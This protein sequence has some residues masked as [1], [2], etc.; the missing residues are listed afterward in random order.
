MAE[1][2]AFDDFQGP[3]EQRAVERL[4]EDLPKGWTLICNKQIVQNERSREIDVI[5][6]APHTV[7][8]IEE[9]GW[10]GVIRGTENGW[11]VHGELRSSPL[12]QCEMSSKM[13]AGILRNTV[14]SRLNDYRTNLVIGIV[15]MSNSTV[16]PAIQDSRAKNRVVLL[17]DAARKMMEL[18]NASSNA[19]FGDLQKKI[20]EQLTRLPQRKHTPELIGEFRITEQLDEQFGCEV[21]RGVHSDGSERILKVFYGAELEDAPSNDTSVRRQY[22]AQRKLA[23]DDLCPA[24]DPYFRW[25]DGRALV[26]PFAKP[27]GRTLGQLAVDGPSPEQI[28]PVLLEAFRTLTKVSEQGVVHRSLRPDR[29][30]WDPDKKKIRL[31]DF[32]IARL[33]GQETVVDRA[34]EF[35][36]D[37]PY[38]ALEARI[39]LSDATPK[40]DVY[41]LAAVLLNWITGEEP[42]TDDCWS[43]PRL[44]GMRKDIED[45]LCEQIESVL[46]PALRFEPG[47]RPS[48]GEV[49]S[50]AVYAIDA[51]NRVTSVE[52][53]KVAQ[54]KQ[55]GDP[56]Y[57]ILES[58]GKG[59]TAETFLAIDTVRGELVVL[60]RLMRPDVHGYLA[61]AE[62]RALK[63]LHHDCLPKLIDVYGPDDKF[64]LK[65]EYVEGQSLKDAWRQIR[66]ESIESKL[67]LV[68]RVSGDVLDALQYLHERNLLHRDVTPGNIL[69]PE[70]EDNR[71]LLIDLGLAVEQQEALSRV[72]TPLYLA[73]EVEQAKPVWSARCDIYGLGVLLFELL[74]EKLPYEMDG[75]SR[76][77]TRLIEID[78]QDENDLL[79]SVLTLLRDKACT[80]TPGSRF[81]SAGEMRSAILRS[82]RDHEQR[83]DEPVTTPE[84]EPDN[85]SV[86]AGTKEVPKTALTELINPFVSELRQAFRNSQLGNTNNRGMDSEFSR[87]TYV[88]TE[89]D[90]QV[91]EILSGKWK[92][93]ALSGNPGDGK[94]AFLEEV[95]REL[96]EKGAEERYSNAA[97]WSLKLNGR[98]FVSVYDA[99]ESHDGQS[100]DELL[101]SAIGPL[102]GR[103]NPDAGYTAL[104]AIN[105][106]R[107]QDL[108]STQRLS[109]RWLCD[110]LRDHMQGKA[111]ADKEVLLVDLKH[112]SPIAGSKQD[113]QS[114]FLGLLDA[115]VEP[116]NWMACSQCTAF[117]DCSIRA[118]AVALRNPT[119]RLQIV[120]LLAGVYFLAERRPTIRDLRSA[121]S[122]ALT[123]D[124]DCRQIHDEV[125]QGAGV[126]RRYYNLLFDSAAG[127]DL[128][129]NSFRELDPASVVNPKLDRKLAVGKVNHLFDVSGIEHPEP[130]NH[131][132]EQLPD[133]KR[134][135]FFEVD[136]HATDLQALL[137]PRKIAEFL[138]LVSGNVQLS[139]VLPIVLAGLQRLDRIPPHAS[140]RELALRLD[141]TEDSLIVVRRWQPE[142]FVLQLPDSPPTVLN[143]LP[144]HMIFR[145]A[146]GW[147][148][149]AIGLQMFEL[150]NRAADGLTPDASEHQSLLMEF[151]R[152]KAQLL[153][154][155]THEVML[156]N[157]G[158][159]RSMVTSANGQIQRKAIEVEA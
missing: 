30:W 135:F 41:S 48:A 7:F 49:C 106:G 13:L 134:R 52:E 136:T 114:L 40:S 37:H 110:A 25:D 108:I 123:G 159:D 8:V 146:D 93:V 88:H 12:N 129:L 148:E 141:S 58:L 75:N 121:L 26:V 137:P 66:S 125:T 104:L 61:T 38:R 100:A 76:D 45:P 42:P 142:D 95:K 44:S 63:G 112:R 94:T 152:F 24:V 111:M 70:S 1:L 18:D 46:F 34:D 69:L 4:A 64:H 82:F 11:L 43:P 85:D 54:E 32:L 90:A 143:Y 113:E 102:K 155:P 56:R 73:P 29:V 17:A 53:Q 154:R 77:K 99:S 151:T 3:S 60:K 117:S 83:F 131:N 156:I 67:A 140:T 105:D 74:A 150:L 133:L 15:L 116:Q 50:T 27:A 139:S 23:V 119:P 6:I 5:C 127:E 65:F 47:E 35:D 36:T 149:M 86:K 72:G 68:K 87:N 78:A 130:T 115:F 19:P 14:S 118:N 22:D 80:P 81:E 39:D 79:H 153:T 91:P 16:A 20:K 97:G 2:I 120:E 51:N 147:P 21:Y 28:L 107:L 62:F 158:G 89:L 144:D 132:H 103:K 9:K 10:S 92:C 157:S 122:W 126:H 71:V 128:V 138:G 96:I 109:F 55:A 98:E 124:K 57:E 33:D 145:H 31:S 84:A 59:G 101:K